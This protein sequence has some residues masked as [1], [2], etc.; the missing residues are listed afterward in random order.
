MS[1]TDNEDDVGVNLLKMMLF[2]NTNVLAECTLSLQAMIEQN[3]ELRSEN[4]MLQKY[5]EDHFNAMQT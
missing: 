3:I 5:I 1:D 2:H 4:E